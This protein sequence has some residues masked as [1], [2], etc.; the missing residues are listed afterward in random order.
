MLW[1]MLENISE[2]I[3]NSRSTDGGGVE[4]VHLE[5]M[6]IHNTRGDRKRK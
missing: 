4:E 1:M 3:S 5:E 2:L 6:S